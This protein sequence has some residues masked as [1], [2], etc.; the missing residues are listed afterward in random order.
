VS[1]NVRDIMIGPGENVGKECAAVCYAGL[2][3]YFGNW[4]G[5][6]NEPERVITPRRFDELLID[7]WAPPLLLRVYIPYFGGFLFH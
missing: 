4:N 6:D 1:I 2:A 3:D 7:K 5:K